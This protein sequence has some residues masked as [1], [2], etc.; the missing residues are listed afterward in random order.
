MFE[1]PTY[2]SEYYTIERTV[3]LVV[4]LKATG[5][6]ASIRIEVL[7]SSSDTYSVSSYIRE[8]VTIQ[9]TYPRDNDKHTSPPKDVMMWID[10]EL[11]WVSQKSVDTALGQALGFLRERCVE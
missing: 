8:H 11:P 7:R 6:D 1:A 10:F 2:A 5:E 9:P 3:E 4:R